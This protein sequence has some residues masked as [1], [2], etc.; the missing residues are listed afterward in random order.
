MENIHDFR[1]PVV[2]LIG[3]GAIK[4]LYTKLLPYKLSKALIVTDKNIIKLGHVEI[5]EKILKDLFISYDI[6]DGISH[7][8]CTISF[9]EDALTYFKKRLNI[10]KRDYHFIISVGGGTNH[11]CAKG[12]AIVATNGG[13]I[14]DYEGYKKLTKPSLPVISINTTSGSGSE[15][16]NVTI[17][18][19]DSRRVKM[20]IAD[21][22]MMP[23]I[24]VNDL[25]FMTTMPPKITANSGI[26]VLTHSIEGF[27][28]TEA[29]PITDS[30][31]IDAVKLVFGY[32]RRA[33]KNGSD[34]EAREKMMF[35]GVMGG[36]VLNNAGLGYVH[37]MS[38]QIGALYEEM[39]GACNAAL[40]PHVLEFNSV[41]IPEKRI[42]K[43]SE[44]MGVKATD[45]QDA[46]NKIKHGIQSLCKDIGLPIHLSSIGVDE[47]DL[48]LLS[49]NAEKD[50][51]SSTNPRRGTFA[52]I[53]NIFKA[54]M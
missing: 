30:L 18:R 22:K 50:I 44:A 51:C 41:S 20:V 39:H 27:V 14:E 38:H 6:F 9:V 48:E 19:D 49:K 37:S 42:L 17:M 35:A 36:M 45:K 1:L 11:D 2:N 5:V 34:V 12:I 24:S 43:I 16:T 40:L 7:P 31:A 26:D 25:R 54:A 3:I 46:V 23:I 4:N 15:V 13:D 8:D 47:N 53:I 52:D 28:A 33:Y 29:S 32:L 21:P 10:L